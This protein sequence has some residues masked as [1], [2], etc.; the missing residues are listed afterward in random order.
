MEVSIGVMKISHLTSE[1]IVFS[2]KQAESVKPIVE[3]FRKM[4]IVEQTFYRWKK[5]YIVIGIAEV[6]RAQ[7]APFGNR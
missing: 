4:G 6:S 1:Q 7:T 5:K 2:P 3:V